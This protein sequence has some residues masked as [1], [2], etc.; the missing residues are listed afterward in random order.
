MEGHG[1]TDG[2]AL[3]SVGIR[4]HTDATASDNGVGAQSLQQS[5][6]TDGDSV[7]I[8]NCLIF[9]YCNGNQ[10]WFLFVLY[11]VL[12]YFSLNTGP[13]GGNDSLQPY[14]SK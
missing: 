10:I 9:R 3:P 7:S 1:S 2:T 11:H 8:S 4:H 5:R 14:S 13:L 12:G 6:R